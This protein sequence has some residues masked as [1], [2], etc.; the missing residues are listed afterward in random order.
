MENIINF[1]HDYEKYGITTVV[2]TQNYRSTQPILDA[3]RAVIRKNTHSLEKELNLKKDLQ[4]AHPQYK[5]ITTPIHTFVQDDDNVQSLFIVDEI[6]KL[7][8]E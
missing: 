5:D 4:A 6:G 7:L 1:H 3:S 2:L 8:K